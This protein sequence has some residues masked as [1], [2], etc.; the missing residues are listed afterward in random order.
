MRQT[1]DQTAAGWVCRERED[2]WDGRGY[3]LYNLSVLG[4]IGRDNV[5]PQP[6]QVC[7]DLGR[8]V[9]AAFRP[10]HV[11]LYVAVFD[12][13][14]FAEPRR[15]GRDPHVGS[16]R[17][18]GAEETNSREPRHLLRARR[19]RPRRRAA[20]K[21]DELATAAHSI[22]S[23]ARASSIGGTCRPSALAVLRLIPSSNLVGCS[24]GR[25]DGMV[26]L[27]ILSTK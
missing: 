17:R 12:P 22:T 4:R 1:G 5:N 6:H 15:E 25:S 2:N 16:R 9:A 21:C 8:T 19:E 7:G 14:K 27:R 26:P 13:A 24:T 10:A 20:K 11:D 23:S 18:A 3:L